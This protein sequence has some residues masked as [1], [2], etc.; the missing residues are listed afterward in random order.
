MSAVVCAT[1]EFVG[2]RRQQAATQ[3]AMPM[4]FRSLRSGELLD[5]SDHWFA[6]S[7]VAYS[8]ESTRL[9]TGSW[10]M[11]ARL[12]E[13]STGHSIRE[14]RGHSES[15]RSIAFAPRGD[16]IATASWDGSARVWS[17]ATG[18]SVGAF[19]GHGEKV[20]AV[21]FAPPISASISAPAG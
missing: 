5:L 9:A 3:N 11:T 21:A 17:V 19:Q 18:E 8:P 14:F 2:P 1:I 6:V 15:I 10:D 13:L 7:N 20:H 12:W 4:T 16:L